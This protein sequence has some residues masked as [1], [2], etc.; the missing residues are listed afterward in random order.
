MY[1]DATIAGSPADDVLVGSTATERSTGIPLGGDVIVAIDG[2]AVGDVDALRSYL[3]EVTRPRETIELAILRN[4]D[5]RRIEV[6]LAAKPLQ[7]ERADVRGP[8]L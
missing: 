3:F 6:R 2:T 1:V 7:L 8:S 4:G 5:S